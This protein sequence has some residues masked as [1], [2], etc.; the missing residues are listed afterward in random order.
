MTTDPATGTPI[1][2][3]EPALGGDPEAPREAPVSPQ[4]PLPSPLGGLQGE[5]TL[6]HHTHVHQ[7]ESEYAAALE[8]AKARHPSNRERV[9]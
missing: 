5:P 6:D 9:Q 4:E 7:N 3:S 1:E 8:R 2:E